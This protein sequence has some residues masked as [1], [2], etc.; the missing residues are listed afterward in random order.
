[1]R[2]FYAPGPRRDYR[3]RMISP[4]GRRPRSDAAPAGARSR[5]G[6]AAE[7]RAFPPGSLLRRPAGR[8]LCRHGQSGLALGA[9]RAARKTPPSAGCWNSPPLPSSSVCSWPRCFSASGS[10][11]I[12]ATTGVSRR[13]AAKPRFTASGATRSTP[14]PRA[15]NCAVARNAAMKMSGCVSDAQGSAWRGVFPPAR[16]SAANRLRVWRGSP[17]WSR[18]SRRRSAALCW[19]ASSRTVRPRPRRLRIS[20]RDACG[21]AAICPN[22]R[23]S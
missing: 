2:F 14:P 10:T 9:W 11:M 17:R 4:G 19:Q 3:R 5:I 23:R 8:A 22:R 16:P 6:V 12:V 15:P 7:R 18:H 1:V 21:G 13:S 20:A